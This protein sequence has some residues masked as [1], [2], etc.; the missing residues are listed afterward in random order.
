MLDMPN[1]RMRRRGRITA[2][3]EERRRRG[4]ALETSFQFAPE[5]A[6]YRVQEADVVA[7]GTL[8]LRLIYAPAC[9]GGWSRSRMR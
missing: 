6:G 4:Y 7:K 9:C 8:V 1:V 5:A 2:D 3:E